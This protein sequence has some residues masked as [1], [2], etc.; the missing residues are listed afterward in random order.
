M[1]DKK[2]SALTAAS[3]AA[4]ANELPINEAGTTKKLTLTQVAALMSDIAPGNFYKV[5][6]AGEFTSTSTSFVDVTGYTT[7]AAVVLP[8]ASDVEINVMIEYQR[9]SVAASGQNQ[10]KILR[11]STD[12]TSIIYKDTSA[13]TGKNEC[14]YIYALD[15]N[16][17]A[18]TY[19]YKLQAQNGS[20]ATITVGTGVMTVKVAATGV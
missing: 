8:V 6:K 7:G 20:A 9:S 11:D 18:G 12:V 5:T 16:V 10:Y 4:A 15:Q 14:V 2:I 1:A 19:T 17:A 13:G 3:S